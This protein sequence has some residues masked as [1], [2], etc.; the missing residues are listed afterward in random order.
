MTQRQIHL[1]IKHNHC[2]H[3]IK[4][5]LSRLYHIAIGL[6]AGLIYLGAVY[7]LSLWRW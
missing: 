4:L 6:L 5:I 3:N 1:S 7:Y 2:R